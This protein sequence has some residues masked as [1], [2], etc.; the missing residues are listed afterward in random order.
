MTSLHFK[1]FHHTHASIQSLLSSGETVNWSSIFSRRSHCSFR[2]SRIPMKASGEMSFLC[3]KRRAIGMRKK[4]YWVSVE[5]WLKHAITF[6]ALRPAVVAIV[7]DFCTAP[8]HTH[9]YTGVVVSL[10]LA[11]SKSSSLRLEG[12]GRPRVGVGHQRCLSAA[13]PWCLPPSP[14]QIT[15]DLLCFWDGHSGLPAG[16]LP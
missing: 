1:L 6:M 15:G 13:A 10:R 12:E 8:P 9:T 4:S 11:R 14:R 7:Y 3:V 2:P 5:L 16:Y